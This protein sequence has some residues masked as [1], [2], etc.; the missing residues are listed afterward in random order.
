M[1]RDQAQVKRHMINSRHSVK[2][3]A[4]MLFPGA[5]VCSVVKGRHPIPA[6]SRALILAAVSAYF[7]GNFDRKLARASGVLTLAFNREFAAVFTSSAASKGEPTIHVEDARDSFHLV[8][9]GGKFAVFAVEGVHYV[10]CGVC[11]EALVSEPW[12]MD[13]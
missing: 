5:F 13:E 4:D 12:F 10:M 7:G 6:V 8:R 1:P 9:R 3:I 11:C 2:D